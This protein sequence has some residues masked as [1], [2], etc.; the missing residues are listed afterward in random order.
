VFPNLSIVFNGTGFVFLITNWPTG[1]ST[2][3][4]CVHWCSS[5]AADANRET[6]DALI[7]ALS[8]VLFEDLDVL[9]GVQRSLDAGALESLRLGYHERRIYYLHE[10]IDRAIGVESIPE[11]LR[12][13]QILG[14]NAAD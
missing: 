7:A 8:Q 14:P 3:T 4:Y 10:T 9:P 6:H 11:T 12:V 1:P 13:P 2:S 5:L